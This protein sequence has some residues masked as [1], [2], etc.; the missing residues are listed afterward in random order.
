MEEIEHIKKIEEEVANHVQD[1]R[2]KQIKR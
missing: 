2:I 1:A